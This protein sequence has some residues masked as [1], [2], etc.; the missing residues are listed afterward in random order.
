MTAID[1]LISFGAN[2]NSTYHG[3][4]PST[5][6]LALA[7]Y[8]GE[9]TVVKYLISHGANGTLL[10]SMGRN[11]LHGL[12]KYFPERHGYLP[13]SWHFWI[14]HGNLEHN[15]AQMTNL[16]KTL[17]EA[18]VDVN[19]KD[20][21]YPPL[22]P[23]A[24]AADLGVW[25]AGAICALLE[26]G[27]DLKESILS[28]G[29]TVLHSWV[30]IVGPRLDYPN[31]YLPTLSKIANAM[32]NVDIHNRF[33]EDTPLHLLTTTYH[34]E[35]EFESACQILLAHSPP[36]D[37]NARTRRG[38]TP[39]SIALE[40]NLNPARRGRFLL[41]KGADP[42]ALNDRGRDI[43]HGIAN[44]VVLPDQDTHDL[45]QRFLLHLNPDI[46]KAYKEHYLPN[47]NSI[48]SLSAAADRG[49]PLT[50]S[51][52]LSLG[53]TSCINKPDKTKSPPWTP[54]D[55]ALHS[56]EL[57]RR[58]HIQG[59]ASYKAGAAR[60]RAL[61]QNRVYDEHQGPPS[62]AAE[63]YRCYPEVIQILCN[64]G[65]KRTCELEGHLKGDYIEQPR[66]WDMDNIHEYGFTPETQPNV[67]M[68]S[69]LYGLARYGGRSWLGLLTGGRKGK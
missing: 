59:L 6:P 1:A 26:A 10:D 39:L 8:F 18:G 36:A 32:P 40:T 35:D 69:G 2:V 62:R 7:A 51:L 55:Q 29:D 27:A 22:T 63:A 58:A 4:D 20:K 46:Q 25:D 30:C 3:S 24:A 12:T 44:N 53:L 21:G 52:L 16:V 45:I 61:K 66:D 65:A 48:D 67:E 43:F 33:E 17:I 38:A 50:L 11:T 64:A 57:S 19:A 9:P 31:S 41:D 42:L 49:K 34:S 28:A 56:A 68:W 54:L 23:I 47:P 37:I 5:T 15:L 60:T 13:H 14:R